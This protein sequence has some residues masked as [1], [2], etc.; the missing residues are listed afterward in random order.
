MSGSRDTDGVF[1][2][3]DDDFVAVDHD[4][5]ADCAWYFRQQP[6]LPKR[7]QLDDLH[8]FV[9]ILSVADADDCVRVESAFPEHERCSKEKVS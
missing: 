4:D 3:D 9:Q 1:E 2:T 8:P 7:S 6:T 5:V